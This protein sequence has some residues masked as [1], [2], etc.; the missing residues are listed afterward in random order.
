MPVNRNW[1]QEFTLDLF[2]KITQIINA[3]TMLMYMLIILLKSLIMIIFISTN[4]SYFYSNCIF[5]ISSFLFFKVIVIVTENFTYHV[6]IYKQNVFKFILHHINFRWSHFIMGRRQF[7][8]SHGNVITAYQGEFPMS[9]RKECYIYIISSP[10]EQLFLSVSS[11]GR[12]AGFYVFV[13]NDSIRTSSDLCYSD[14]LSNPSRIINTITTTEVNV[15]CTYPMTG[16]YVTIYNARSPGTQYPLGYS[17]YAVL[18]LCEVEVHLLQDSEGIMW[19]LPV[20]R[21]YTFFADCG[22]L[23]C[24]SLRSAADDLR[25]QT[26]FVM[27][28]TANLHSFILIG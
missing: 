13:S 2:L 8:M 1:V 14:Q 21:W 7:W 6:M 25:S 3:C 28:S 4:L 23:P 15:T 17:S 22:T 24:R 20:I 18:E 11:G 19:L 27:T 16:R 5:E 10:V 12:L 26:E 9:P